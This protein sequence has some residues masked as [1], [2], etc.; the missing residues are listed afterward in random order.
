[1]YIYINNKERNKNKK[2]KEK[3]C[4]LGYIQEE[5]TEQQA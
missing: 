2:K 4:R 1:M 3:K 5:R